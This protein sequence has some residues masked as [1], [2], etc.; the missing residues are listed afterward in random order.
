MTLTSV[1]MINT[2]HPTWSL[3]PITRVVT[4]M[5]K[6]LLLITLPPVRSVSLVT[7]TDQKQSQQAF[8][9]AFHSAA[10]LSHRTGASPLPHANLRTVA[11]VCNFLVAGV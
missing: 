2:V 5:V 10:G 3:C 6:L 11:K 9:E 1:Q 7:L 8:S 4:G